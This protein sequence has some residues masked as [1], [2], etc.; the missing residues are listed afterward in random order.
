MTCFL[1][2]NIIFT[3]IY[4]NCCGYDKWKN[5]EQWIPDWPLQGKILN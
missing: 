5:F 3:G 2:F 1:F 4:T